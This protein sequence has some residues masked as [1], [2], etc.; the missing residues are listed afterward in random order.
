MRN[1][2]FVLVIYL[3]STMALGTASVCLTVLVLNF[4]HRTNAVRVPNWA[5]VLLLQHGARLFRLSVDEKLTKS[6]DMR[7]C[8]SQFSSSSPPPPPPLS[9]HCTEVNKVK[10]GTTETT[11]RAPSD[12]RNW[13]CHGDGQGLLFLGES[14]VYHRIDPSKESTTYSRLGRGGGGWEKKEKKKR[15][16]IG[17]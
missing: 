10:D 11:D 15:T 17:G 5:R 13:R 3:S 4:H 16:G 12:A 2:S 7:G 9:P 8:S 1:V 14:L 6:Q